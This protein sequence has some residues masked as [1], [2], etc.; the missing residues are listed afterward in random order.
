MKIVINA[1]FLT[2]SITGVQRFAI[3]ISRYLKKELGE[4]AVF[5]SPKNIIHSEIAEELNVKILGI[6]RFHLWEQIDLPLFLLK[7]K[8]PLLLNLC[9]TAPL[10]YRNNIVTIH[11]IAFEIFPQAYSKEFLLLYKYLLPSIARSS[12]KIITVSNFSKSEIIRLYNISVDKIMVV[13]NAVNKSFCAVQNE[14]LKKEQYFLTVSSLNYRK[15]LKLVLNAFNILSQTDEEIRLYIVGDINGKS[16][17]RYNLE[18]FKSNTKISFLGRL[19]DV[20][21]MEYYTNTIAFIYPSLYEGFGIPPL[22][23]QKCEAPVIVSD[24]PCFHEVFYD[25][26]LYTNTE[27][28]YELK[29]KMNLFRDEN[30]RALYIKKGSQNHIK[31]SWEKSGS[32]VLK[33]ILKAITAH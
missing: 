8:S 24:I 3:E 28:H 19:S 29:D 6:N 14:E 17:S 1:R 13:N 16:F 23:A 4:D 33:I 30:Y 9:N 7:N 27:N 26:V 31:Y 21:L 10:F 32:E 2:Q 15:N 12:K 20:R 5:V 25:S 22:E 18:E 11:D